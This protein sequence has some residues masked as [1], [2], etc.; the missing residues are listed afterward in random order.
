MPSGPR[1]EIL[2]EVVQRR[3]E[4]IGSS[5]T[6]AILCGKARNPL[7]LRNEAPT[8]LC[9]IRSRGC[10]SPTGDVMDTASRR[11][12]RK[13]PSA[14]WSIWSSGG[15]SNASVKQ[16]V[17][18]SIMC[19]HDCCGFHYQPCYELRPENSSAFACVA[20]DTRRRACALQFTLV[21]AVENELSSCTR[22]ANAQSPH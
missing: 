9:F 17:G 4:N 8:A 11:V 14:T 1:G 21:R 5:Q 20:F 19:G 12:L 2:V 22:Q 10:T 13:P 3:L 6:I 18:A 7:S 16:T 15:T